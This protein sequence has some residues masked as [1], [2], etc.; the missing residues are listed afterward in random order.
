MA[1]ADGNIIERLERK[2]LSGIDGR[3]EVVIQKSDAR[4]TV[5]E[6]IVTDCNGA[7][8]SNYR[9]FDESF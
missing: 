8:R 5:A 7:S 2:W 4:Y 1:D 9:G 3:H 6:S